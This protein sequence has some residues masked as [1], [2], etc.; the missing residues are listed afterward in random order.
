MLS[1]VTGWMTH[2]GPTTSAE[3]GELLGIPA[4]D[5]ESNAADRGQWRD[6][7]GKVHRNSLAGGGA[8]ATQHEPSMNGA[9]GGCLRVFIASRSQR[10]ASR[11]SQ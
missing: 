3:L 6:S 9:T 8:R 11:S 10:C 7:P 2:I 5:R 1:L 4:R